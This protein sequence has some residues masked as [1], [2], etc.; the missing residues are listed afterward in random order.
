MQIKYNTKLLNEVINVNRI[1]TIIKEHMING[2]LLSNKD[3]SNYVL[4]LSV[5]KELDEYIERLN[6]NMAKNAYNSADKRLLLNPYGIFKKSNKCPLYSNSIKKIDE[7][8]SAHIGINNCLNI[9]RLLAVNHETTHAEQIKIMTKKLSDFE[10]D[11]FNLLR[12]ILIIT[13]QIAGFY[14][15]KYFGNYAYKNFHD[16]F[17]FEYDAWITSYLEVI[18]LMN[19]FNLDELHNQIVIINE[20]F[21]SYIHFAYKSIKDLEKSS[22]PRKNSVK[23]FYRILKQMEENNISLDDDNTKII[24]E[25]E[26][27]NFKIPSD[28]LESLRLGLP[29]SESVHSYIDDIAFKRKKTL[30]LFSDI[31][32]IK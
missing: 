5:E 17:F 22:T 31:R 14:D 3:L 7:N 21:A 9:Y 8:Y 2:K 16:Y 20:L 4:R 32:S 18:S 25:C 28:Q 26:K 27:I 15:E 11:D 24:N 30:N 29:L 19:S 23:I 10:E 12:Y 13:S 1:Y 6:F